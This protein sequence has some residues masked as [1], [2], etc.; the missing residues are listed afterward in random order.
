MNFYSV[1]NM[2]IIVIYYLQFLQSFLHMKK[3][4]FKRLR[5]LSKVTHLVRV[6]ALSPGQ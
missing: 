6:R 4:R 5:H 3:Q 1:G 2:K